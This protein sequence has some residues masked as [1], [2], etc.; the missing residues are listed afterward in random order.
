MKI[1]AILP[2]SVRGS[3]DN[4]DLGRIEIFF[5]SLEAFAEADMF[6]SFLIVT[7]PDET[8][9]VAKK[10][11]KWPQF[12]IRVLSEEALVP[13]L[14]K[15]RHVRGWRKQQIV[16]LAA[17]REINEDFYLTLDAD[18]VCL[19]PLAISDLIVNGRALIQYEQRSQH[20]KWWKS[21]SKLL[22]MNP[23][24]GDP[25]IGM[26]VTPALLSTYLCKQLAEQLKPKNGGSWVDR[27]CALHNPKSPSNWTIGRLLRSKWT[28]YS[29]Y[30]LCAMK[31][32][33]LDKYH[34]RAGTIETPQLLL[35]HDS[36]P[37]ETW[38]VA[39]S[40]SSD[41]PGL[42]CVVGSKS[43]IEPQLVWDTIKPYIPS[44]ATE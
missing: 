34:I 21:S 44:S 6:G 37:F 29:L 27:L 14:T 33:L 9:I 31:L 39:N 25:S 20:P 22:K 43:G 17:A 38:D 5:R 35:I 42:F 40:F 30:Y 3:Y 23:N 26:T 8:D 15:Y 11:L 18:V 41:N 4:D 1:G 10:C 7:P 19:G 12:N 16:K 28:E 24:V 2:L 13:E 32:G 36:H